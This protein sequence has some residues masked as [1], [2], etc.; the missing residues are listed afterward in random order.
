MGL[1]LDSP[2][3][4]IEILRMILSWI[5]DD[6]RIKQVKKPTVVCVF[7]PFASFAYFLRTGPATFYTDVRS[8]VIPHWD[9]QIM[10][11]IKFLDDALALD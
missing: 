10:A 2:R 11:L 1:I 8:Q 4:A 3:P 9:E 5:V 7:Y 6:S